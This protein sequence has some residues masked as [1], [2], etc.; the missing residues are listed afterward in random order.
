MVGVYKGTYTYTDIF[1]VIFFV[2][3]TV[4]LYWLGTALKK[5][6]LSSKIQVF[7]YVMLRRFDVSEKPAAST[8]GSKWLLLLDYL[9][10]TNGGCKF[11]WKVGNYLQIA[12]TS[13]SRWF[14]SSTPLWELQISQGAL[15]MHLSTPKFSYSIM[16]WQNVSS[17]ERTI[18]LHDPV[19][20]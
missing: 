12:K 2:Q 6:A 17:G 13:Y 5:Q 14:E 8:P 4:P 1:R 20:S 19:N 16:V 18:L 11:L 15:V 7:W 9:D 3:W 10:P